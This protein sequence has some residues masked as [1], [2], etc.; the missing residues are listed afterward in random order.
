MSSSPQL[1][2][3]IP[4]PKAG[5]CIAKVPYLNSVPFFRGWQLHERWQFTEGVPRAVGALAASG[6]IVAGTLPL[7]DYLR[8]QDQFERLG[9][10]G[11]AVRGRARSALLFARKPLR[12]LGVAVVAVTEES[13][14]TA[15][16]LRLLL[17]QR[18]HVTPASY[19]AGRCNDADAMLLIGDEAIRFQRANTQYPYEID[20]AFEWWLWQHLPCVF[21]V[22]AVRKDVSAQEKKSLELS[23]ARSLAINL[24]QL[25]AIAQDASAQFGLP[26]EEIVAYL[27]GFIYRLGSPE[28]AAIDRFQALLHDPTT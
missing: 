1:T 19:H 20:V 12:Q 10:F 7:A 4:R 15:R 8:L 13:S 22:W 18:Y 9:H 3:T 28:H 17:E 14:T 6:D 2:Y 25:D 27:S 16:L 5:D 26:A 24:G 23:L 21:A 11:I